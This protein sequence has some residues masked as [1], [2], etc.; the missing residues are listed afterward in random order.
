MPLAA[1]EIRQLDP[2]SDPDWDAKLASLP[3]ATFFHSSAWAR[4]LHDTYGFSPVYFVLESRDS[5]MGLPTHDPSRHESGDPCH[6]EGAGR[7]LQGFP[8]IQALL[9]VMEVNSWLTGR[10]GVSL[11]F[12]DSCAPLCADAE[13]FSR[14][15][16]AAVARGKNR[17]WSYLEL[18]GGRAWFGDAPAS[19]AFLGHRLDLGA[20]EKALFA[21][22][23]SAGRRAVRKAEQSGLSV[24]FSQSTGA[25]R[26]FYDLLCITRKRHG[27]PPQPFAFFSNIQRHVLAQKR[28]WVVM[29]RHGGVA[30]AGAVFFHHGTTALY[31]FGA[32]DEKYQNLRGNNLVMWAAIKRYAAEGF[33]AFDFGRTSL[34]NDGLRRFKLGWGAK[35]YPI[36][37]V[38]YDLRAGRYVTA[39]DESSGWHNRFF[40]MLPTPLFRLIGAALYRHVA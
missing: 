20:G 7:L 15:R 14:L 9:P 22:I 18:R 32:S 39:K 16:D 38:R 23:E 3:G 6:A 19:T 26:A 37:Y 8:R 17:R 29:A 12:T 35:E 30:V 33:A 28:G 5:G 13:S 34:H 27:I 2:L 4:V 31:K 40:R 36:E 10:R 25:I 21:G 24:E 11:P 1:S